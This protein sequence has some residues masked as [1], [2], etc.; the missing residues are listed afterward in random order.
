MK[1][2]VKD[3]K[4]NPYRDLPHYPIDRKRVEILKN[5]IDSTGFWDNILARKKDGE[6]EIAYGHHRLI[7]LKESLGP[8]HEIDIPV[9]P[10]ADEDML[11][12]MANENETMFEHDPRV[13]IETVKQAKAFLEK[14]PEIVAK[15]DKSTR[16]GLSPGG[17]TPEVGKALICRFLGGN[18]NEHKVSTALQ[19]LKVADPEVIKKAPT[20]K[21]VEYISRIP[22]K[23]VQKKILE[24]VKRGREIDSKTKER[25]PLTVDETQMEVTREKMKAQA[26]PK[27]PRELDL[28][29]VIEG[30]KEALA[31]A[32][33]LIT[34]SVVAHWGLVRK[35]QKQQILNLLANFISKI[36][37]LYKE[38]KSAGMKLIGGKVRID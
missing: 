23:K 14:N 30:I 29:D 25:R 4:P 35:E 26:G 15:L 18:W 12:I 24:K 3:L 1:V 7:A 22:D 16:A 6:I 10:L 33:A 2:K 13:V 34:K 8:N 28:S 5:S 20:L 19:A 27:Q 17:Q 32:S 21:H 36:Q 9:K 37:P 38:S 11:K 31:K